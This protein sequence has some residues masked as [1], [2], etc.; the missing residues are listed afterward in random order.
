[1]T[2]LRTVASAL[3]CALLLPTACSNAGAE[4]RPAQDRVRART[5][6]PPPS[7]VPRHVLTA[8]YFGGEAGTHVVA[9]RAM[10]KATDWVETSPYDTTTW[11]SGMH[12]M[13]YTDPN[14]QIS[15]EPLWT[16]NQSAFA[17]D[18]SGHRIS[19][20]YPSVGGRRQFLMDPHSKAMFRT[21]R[22]YVERFFS[23]GHFAA[24]FDDDAADLAYMDA[25]PCNAGDWL[26]A[27]MREIGSLHYPVVYNGLEPAYHTQRINPTIALNRV[28][29]G[30]MMEDCY[31]ERPNPPSGSRWLTEERTE[32]AMKRQRKLFFCYGNQTSDASSSLSERLYEDASF[33]LTYDPK[34]SILWEHWATASGVHVM[35]ESRFV[36]LQPKRALRHVGDLNDG[37]LYVRSYYRCYLDARLLGPCKVV[38]NPGASSFAVAAGSLHHA[39]QLNGSGL[40]DDGRVGIGPAPSSLGPVSAAILVR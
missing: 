2:I 3:I 22:S 33:L 35:P 20:L 9:A 19:R 29:I 40:F 18:C 31:S 38:V 32:L 14:R 36:P 37:G 30:G 21:W 25:L 28:A 12:V 11:R 8:D 7:K 34:R 13:F 16:R 26:D 24:V 27:S 10:A 6:P 4:H 39:L 5:E 1:M 17:R 15:H 23:A